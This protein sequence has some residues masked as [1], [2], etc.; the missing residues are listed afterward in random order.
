[1]LI[2]ISGHAGSGKDAMA[3]YLCRQY[4]FVKVGLA[5]PLKRYCSDAF[6]FSDQQ[7]YGPSEFRNA[8]DIRY[9]RM[10]G[11][12]LSPREALQ[13]LGTEFGR[14]CYPNVWIDYAVRIHKKLRSGEYNYHQKLGVFFDSARTNHPMN[15]VCSDVRFT[16][17]VMGF[18]GAGALLIRLK[19]QGAT[20][21][22]GIKGHASEEEQKSFKDEWFDV[23][24]DAPE[25]LS[26]FFARIDSV[27]GPH[28]RHLEP[29]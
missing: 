27:L 19:R 3:D 17:E 7:L 13:R 15:V 10:D 1:M 4:N 2:A 28:L 12:C 8:P 14:T 11:S 9:P 29:K 22:V 26:A 25:G 6:D 18:K 20:G 5:D 24:I 16:N 23:V 21:D